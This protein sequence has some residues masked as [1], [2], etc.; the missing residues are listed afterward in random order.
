[1][2]ASKNDTVLEALKLLRSFGPV[3]SSP[4]KPRNFAGGGR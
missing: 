2:L 3:D 4:K 1:M